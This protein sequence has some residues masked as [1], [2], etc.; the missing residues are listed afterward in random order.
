MIRTSYSAEEKKTFEQFRY[1]YPDERIMRRFEILWLH[2]CGKI[3]TEIAPLV[4]RDPRTVRTVLK[5]FQQGGIELVTTIKSNQPTSELEAHRTSI[6]DEFTRQ[7]PASAKEAAHRIKKLTGLERSPERVR[8][9]MKNLGMQFRKVGAIPAKADLEKQEDFKKKV[10]EPEIARAKAG[11]SVLLFM[12][13][14]HFVQAAFLA[15]LWSFTRIFVRSP[16]GRKRWNV[17]GAFNAISGQ[18]TMVANDGY[19][20]ATTV[21]ELLHKLA[22]QYAG[23]PIVIVLDNARYQHCKLVKELAEDLGITLQFLPSYSPNLNLIERL[24]KFVKKKCLNNVYYETFDDFKKGINDCLNSIENEHK[25]ELETLMKTN[26]QD[27]KKV[28]LLTL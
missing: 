27:L 13:G 1:S 2:A 5:N 7:P 25:A 26:F 11:E 21:C 4:Q 23:K 19:I 24:W 20:T 3:A 22:A 16:S 6:I 8:V 18:F 28:Q 12:D 10:L 15:Y 17:L 9:F 14:V